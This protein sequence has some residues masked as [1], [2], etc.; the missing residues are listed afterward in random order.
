MKLLLNDD[1]GGIVHVF[2]VFAEQ[3]IPMLNYVLLIDIKTHLQ[4]IQ[5]TVPLNVWLSLVS[6]LLKLL[7]PVQDRSILLLV[8]NL[9]TIKFSK[10]SL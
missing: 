6:C 7:L 4:G 8:C 9:K 2:L 3:P 5:T 10:T 1:T